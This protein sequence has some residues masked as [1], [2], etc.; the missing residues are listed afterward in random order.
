M[1]NWNTLQPTNTNVNYILNDIRFF[2][3]WSRATLRYLH[4]N[5]ETELDYSIVENMLLQIGI[6]RNFER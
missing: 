4:I 5:G 2:P 3:L 1:A 6:P